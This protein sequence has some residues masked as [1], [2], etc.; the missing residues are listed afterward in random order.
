MFSHD[1]STICTA[2]YAHQFGD[3]FQET[4]NRTQCNLAVNLTNTQSV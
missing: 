3:G 1:S 4:V 2:I